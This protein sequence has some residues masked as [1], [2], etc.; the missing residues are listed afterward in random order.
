MYQLSSLYSGVA[1]EMVDS[2]KRFTY[3][4]SI[5]YQDQIT[6]MILSTLVACAISGPFDLINTKLVTQQYPKYQGTIS[7]AKMVLREE[8][9]KK[10]VFSGYG[11]RS[12]FHCLQAV[13]VF[14]LYQKVKDTFGEAFIDDY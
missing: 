2:K 14:N 6:A 3:S 5:T 13:I 10:L 7:T 11:A 1:N 9:Y 12:S 8:G 4:Y